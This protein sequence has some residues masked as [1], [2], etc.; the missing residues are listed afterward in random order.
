M[1]KYHFHDMIK[2]AKQFKNELKLYKHYIAERDRYKSQIDMIMDKMTSIP[3]PF[4]KQA[5][6]KKRVRRKNKEGKYYYKTVNKSVA[7]PKVRTSDQY[8]QQLMIKRIEDKNDCETMMDYY[9]RRI[10]D[11]EDTLSILPNDLKRICFNVFVNN[12]W[13]EEA[14]KV[15]YSKSGLHKYIDQRLR[16]ALKEW[17]VHQ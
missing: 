11:I 7:E 17:T 15:G 10:D 8:K 9:Q 2:D 16:V 6:I 5:T 3:S 4:P 13:E 14:R 1:E 12:I